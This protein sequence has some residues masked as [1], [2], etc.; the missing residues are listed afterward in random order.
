MER[1]NYDHST[2]DGIDVDT[3]ISLKEYGIAW[4]KND[5]DILFY[6]GIKNGLNEYNECECILFD[7]CSISLDT[8]IKSNYDWANF[9]D[10]NDYIGGS[11]FDQTIEFKIVDLLNYYGYENVFG[12]SY[13]GGITYNEII[14]EE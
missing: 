12:S 10:V 5:T 8:D 13:G 1:K 9:D 4:V 2:I 6:Y 14:G 7:Q 11:F 3:E